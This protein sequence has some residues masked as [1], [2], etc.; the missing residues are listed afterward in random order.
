MGKTLR[1]TIKS[2]TFQ[3]LKKASKNCK[4][5]V[6]K[7]HRFG[8]KTKRWEFINFLRYN[9]IGSLHWSR[10]LPYDTNLKWIEEMKCQN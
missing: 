8:N 4:T 6:L 7:I 1:Q 2:I 3:H 5:D 10:Y 9:K